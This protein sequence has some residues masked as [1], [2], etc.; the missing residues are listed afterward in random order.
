MSETGSESRLCEIC[1]KVEATV[2]LSEVSREIPVEGGKENPVE[3]L[4]TIV[5]KSAP[6]ALGSETHSKRKAVITVA[7][8]L[9]NIRKQCWAS[10]SGKEKEVAL[11]MPPGA[12]IS[13]D[14]VL[15]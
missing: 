9:H 11:D 7:I 5:A 10:S 8:N 1:K 14:A 2:H 4:P 6:I 15:W 3:S 12:D 13:S